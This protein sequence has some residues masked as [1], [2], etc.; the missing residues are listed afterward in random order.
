[1]PPTG[2]VGARLTQ[3]RQLSVMTTLSF[4]SLIPRPSAF[5]YPSLRPA[6]PLEHNQLHHPQQNYQLI[7]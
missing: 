7:K 1:M 4:T 2:G 5:Q 6:T 3:M